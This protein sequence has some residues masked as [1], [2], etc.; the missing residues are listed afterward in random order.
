MSKTLLIAALAGLVV[1]P[2]LASAETNCQAH[3]S[4]NR[5]IGTIIGAGLGALFGNAVA[6]HGGKPGGT[7]I[8]GI[9]GGVAGNLIAG[10][11]TKCDENR[12]GYYDQDGKW[13]PKTSNTQGYYDA[14]GQ[15]VLY[16][17]NSSGGNYAN[18][19]DGY[20][21]RNGQWVE[22]RQESYN[23]PSENRDR[24]DRW[25]ESGGDTRQREAWLDHRFRDGI[26]EGR[27]DRDDGHR[28]LH[29]LTDLRNLDSDYR[30]ADGRLDSEQ[31]AYI[32]GRLEHLKNR[33]ERSEHA[34]QDGPRG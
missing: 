23:Q 9:G 1:A 13:I 10:S 34:S 4:N 3:R 25:H 14:N 11:G 24:E 2:S 29:E 21:D 20:Y 6:E 31:Q 5:A 19:N 7:I 12:Y 27:I 28:A 15:W 33:L 30:A 32:D 22:R 18:Q 26:A 17:A 8:G 16:S